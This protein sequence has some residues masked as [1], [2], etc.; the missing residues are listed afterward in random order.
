[1]G[2][3]LPYGVAQVNAIGA[4]SPVPIPN[5]YMAPIEVNIVY[6]RGAVRETRQ[7]MIECFVDTAGRVKSVR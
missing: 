3:A 2:A 4:G 7:A 1:V 5:G 6:A